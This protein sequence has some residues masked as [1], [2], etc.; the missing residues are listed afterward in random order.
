[1][2]TGQ[3]WIENIRQL[4]DKQLRDLD[5]GFNKIMEWELFQEQFCGMGIETI[6]RFINEECNNRWGQELREYYINYKR[7]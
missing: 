2:A 3:Q 1:M 7:R 5:D 4:T 6:Q